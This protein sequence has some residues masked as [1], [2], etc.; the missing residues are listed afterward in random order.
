MKEINKKFGDGWNN[1]LKDHKTSNSMLDP[2]DDIRVFTLELEEIRK[3][4]RGDYYEKIS[5]S[6]G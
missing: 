5:I 2:K 1:I 4:P 3:S 6:D